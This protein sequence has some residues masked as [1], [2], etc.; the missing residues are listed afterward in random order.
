MKKRIKALIVSAVLGTG[1]LVTPAYATATTVP[2]SASS[3]AAE[4]NE[5]KIPEIS[6]TEMT[7]EETI[8]LMTNMQKKMAETNSYTIAGQI[9]MDV[10]QN[11][12]MNFTMD[13]NM[14]IEKAM[15]EIKMQVMGQNMDTYLADGKLYFKT[16]EPGKTDFAYMPMPVT[17][18]LLRVTYP[19][20]PRMAEIVKA[21]KTENG[22]VLKTGK[23]ITFNDVADVFPEVKFYR[24]FMTQFFGEA[25]KYSTGNSNMP[26]DFDIDKLVSSM[27]D[28]FSGEIL[29]EVNE[30]MTVKDMYIAYTMDLSKVSESLPESERESFPTAPIK[31]FY[32]FN[33]TNYNNAPEIV[34]PAEAKD[35]VSIFEKTE[36][37]KMPSSSNTMDT[38][39][40]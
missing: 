4:T 34:L 20:D 27:F 17:T 30:D 15:A 31:V 10:M 14:N 23:V 18:E 5:M 16:P 13:M 11:M 26:S 8:E 32:K 7:K 36:E 9:F 29:A 39:K 2:S 35:A 37:M 19:V 21:E 33:Y 6:G 12:K 22:Y 1:L 28:G 25:V 24:D 40:N 38:K 3:S